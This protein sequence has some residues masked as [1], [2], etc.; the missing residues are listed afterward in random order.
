MVGFGATARDCNL[1][2]SL[3]QAKGEGLTE[4]LVAASDQSGLAL[5]AE[6]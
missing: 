1:G 3:R 2:A 4:A 5:K 6:W